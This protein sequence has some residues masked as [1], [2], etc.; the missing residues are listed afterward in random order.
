MNRFLYLVY[1]E[2]IRLVRM[3]AY[4]IPTLV[5]PI[6]FFAI[7]GLP[8]AKNQLGGV[9][10]ATYILV[11]FSAYSLIS[12]SL[13]AFGVSIAAERGLGWQKLMRVTPLNP[14]MYFAS[15]VV[16]ALLQGIFIIALLALFASL[17]G[18]LDYDVLLFAKSVGKL[19]IGVSAF[20]AL[21]L[22]IGYVGGPNSAAGI[23]NLIFLPMSFASG[24][25]MPLEFMPEFL[26][27]I[28]PYT[29]AYHFAQI[30]W[31][32]IGAK[33]DTTELVHWAWVAGYAVIFFAMALVA[34]RRDE[35]KNFG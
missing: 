24:L 2:L 7:F 4:L 1:S 35:G 8:N 34:Y 16:N 23:A 22:W 9:N 33:S 17:V 29:P 20:V 27:N 14:L 28:A 15:K 25:F 5:F 21:G 31:M 19:L 12:T 6:M 3:P 13:F 32:N 18:K 30:G 26:R 11:S 10:A